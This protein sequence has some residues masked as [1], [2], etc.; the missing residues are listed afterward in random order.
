MT[1]Y[2]VVWSQDRKSCTIPK[3][4]KFS[5]IYKKGIVTAVKDSIGIMVFKSYVSAKRFM[6]LN[7]KKNQWQILEVN[8]VGEKKKMPKRLCPIRW[9]A[10]E[11]TFALKMYNK[12]R[13]SKF[14]SYY[15]TM[16]VPAGSECY[17][18]VEVM[19]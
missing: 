18:S 10:R 6:N 4:S 17:D 9:D 7:G 15:S 19:D 3:S 12:F 13:F 2:K 5:L 14:P 16:P 11:T 8:P 1:K